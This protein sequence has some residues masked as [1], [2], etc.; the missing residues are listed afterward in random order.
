MRIFKKGALDSNCSPQEGYAYHII[1]I[2]IPAPSEPSASTSWP[3]APSDSELWDDDLF[4]S[5][6]HHPLISLDMYTV[7]RRGGTCTGRSVHP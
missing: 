7:C 2:T 6:H 4:L 1:H 3:R 5:S